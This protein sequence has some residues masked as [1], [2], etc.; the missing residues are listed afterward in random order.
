MILTIKIV[1]NKNKNSSMNRMLD[2]IIPEKKL[3][4]MEEIEKEGML[5]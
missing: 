2:V 4:C 3:D 5:K 1:I